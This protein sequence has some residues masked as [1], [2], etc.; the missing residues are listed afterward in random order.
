[1]LT[2]EHRLG[3]RVSTSGARGPGRFF[4]DAPGGARLRLALGVAGLAVL[5]AW[6]V[7]SEARD[8]SANARDTSAPAV[9]AGEPRFDGH[10][11]WTGYLPY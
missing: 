10:G 6:G 5:V 9:S 1:M 4:Q 2:A 7:V 8:P 3:P 11:K